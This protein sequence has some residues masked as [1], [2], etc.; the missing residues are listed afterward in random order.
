MKPAFGG[1]S[2]LL[3]VLV[4]VLIAPVAAPYDPMAT[5]TG[6]QFQAPSVA[7]WL[8]TDQ[9]GRDVLS[10]LLHG[11]QRT[12]LV[13]LAATGIAV[14]GGT[15]L[16]MMSAYRSNPASM[17][18]PGDWIVFGAGVVM[19]A[20]FAVPALVL[21]LAVVTLLG[22]G[23]PSLALATGISQVAPFARLIATAARQAAAMPYVEAARSLG[24]REARL[25]WLHMLPNLLPTVLSTTVIAFAYC[26]LNSAA[27]SFLGL[28]APPGQPDW[29]AMLFEGRQVFRVA[30]WVGLAPGVAITLLVALALWSAD[31]VEVS[32]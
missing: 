31:K 15:L 23:L 9:F 8:G 10:R 19:S 30:I 4:V 27:L 22:A 7:H 26:L 16:G 17:S 6:A 25:L 28:G 21:A 24:A 14:V 1:I 12:L 5:N 13:T 29:G 32:A 18:C 11:G 20:L 3:L 2:P